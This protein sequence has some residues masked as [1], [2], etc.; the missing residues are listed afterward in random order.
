[1]AVPVGGVGEL[2][3]DEGVALGAV[4]AGAL[5][6]QLVDQVR[7]DETGQEVVHD[8]PLVVPREGSS[9]FVE[10]VALRH[11]V[12]AEPVGEE[13]VR[14]DEG[15]LH[16]AHE[17]VDV[18]A[19]VADQG[20][21]LL[22]ARQV[23]VVLEE[24][25]GIVA[26]VEVG[27]AG[28]SSAVE[29]LEVG[30]RGAHVAKRLDVGV[31]AKRRAVGGEVV[32]D[33]L[34]E[35]RPARFHVRV[36]LAIPA[37]AEAAGRAEPVEQRLVGVEARK[38]EHAPVSAAGR[39]RGVDPLGSEAVVADRGRRGDG[40]RGRHG[41]AVRARSSS[42]VSSAVGSTSRRSSGIG[43]PLSTDKP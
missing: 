10:Q 8:Q 18:V 5:L 43:S 2:D 19:R 34:A 32:G 42:A 13:V 23:A 12:G 16:L 37:V 6:E 20:D 21:A 3:R 29:R 9:S 25:H 7:A 39:E 36:V 33:V 38:V 15:H 1:M 40:R 24:L 30:T 35:E 41:S 14:A 17:R 4:E 27:G 31:G 28:R 11:A 26:P 22:V